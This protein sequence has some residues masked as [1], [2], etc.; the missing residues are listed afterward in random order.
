MPR[1][2]RYS[3]IAAGIA[4][5]ALMVAVAPA[6]AGNPVTYTATDPSPDT[7]GAP[8]I[9]SVV[10]SDNTAG[11]ITIQLNFAPGTEQQSQDSFG[12]YIDSDQNPTTGDTSAA[13]TD[14]LVQWAGGTD[15]GLGLYKWDGS[16][17]YV[18]TD[19]SSLKGSFSGDSQYFVIAASEL[20]ITDGFN[21][22]VAAAVGPDSSTSSQIDFIP[23]DGTNAHYSMQSK[24]QI[25]LKL[26]D[27]EDF[28]PE[29]GKTYATAI[30]ATR[31]DTGA[32]LTA[33]ATITCTLKVG[34]RTVTG[35]S[36]GFT[37]VRWYK[38]GLKKAA[39]CSWRLPTTSA[40]AKLTAKESVTLAGST[41]SKVYT[42]RIKK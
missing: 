2:F 25:T 28:V 33:G 16:S 18:F 7:S 29:A 19:S 12:V 34:G 24:A 9:T 3:A 6:G 17:S 22:N 27:W 42:A 31:S 5:V 14:Y 15:G 11:L 13:G 20:G 32:P 37:S 4:V 41:V 30:I 36:H 26:S 8:D 10:I 1:T 39:V 23:E 21:F 40:G 38:G 35:A